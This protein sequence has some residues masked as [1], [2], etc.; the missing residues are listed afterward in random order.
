MQVLFSYSAWNKEEKMKAL[1]VVYLSIALALIFT[2]PVSAQN[3]NAGIVAYYSFDDGAG[4]VVKDIVGNNN[5]TINGTPTWVE[6]NIGGGL[7][8][9]GT[10]NFVDCGADPSFNLTQT[11]SIC[12]WVKI[13]AFGN[14]DGIV[15]K[16]VDSG[17]YAMQMWGDGA[18][19]FSPNWGDPA[20]F[21]GKG[22][23][24]TDTKMVAGEWTH[25]AVTYDGAKVNFYING[26]P[27]ALVVEE[28]FTFGTNTDSMILGCDFPGG[29][30]Y[31]DGVMD[32]V[33]IYERAL[34]EAEISQVMTGFVSVNPSGKVAM[35]WGMIKDRD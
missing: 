32:E 17:P 30:E 12:A 5:G 4:D 22:S 11:L 3:L 6:G 7:E 24:N 1:I 8:F 14:W 34:T 31:F 9:D 18:L 23:F 16:G 28:A 29:D 27:D 33:F 25:V 19:R 10:A 20:G 15:T 13:N 21:K 2:P 26:K 35:T